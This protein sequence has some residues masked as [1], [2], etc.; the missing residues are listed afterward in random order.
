MKKLPF[1]TAP[2]QSSTYVVGDAESGLLE[3]KKLGCLTVKEELALVE[4]M[5]TVDLNSMPFFEFQLKIATLAIQFRG[6]ESWEI[7]DTEE[8]TTPLV[9]KTYEFF[10]DKERGRWAD[11]SF[12]VKVE[13]KDSQNLIE[14]YAQD[15]GVIALNS[16]EKD[17]YY[18]YSSESEVPDGFELLS[19][20]KSIISSTEVVK[21]TGESSTGS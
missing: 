3:L 6:D 17:T 19:G 16:S 12:L 13:G 11:K 1:F 20:K 15:K 21:Q 7:A 10:F 4:L 2:K 18:V 8:L 5:K 9:E 14:N